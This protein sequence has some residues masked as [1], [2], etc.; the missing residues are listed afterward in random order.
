MA[1]PEHVYRQSVR[2]LSVVM[3]V[4]GLAII[5]STLARGGG[6]LSVGFLIG[7]AFLVVGAGRLYIARKSG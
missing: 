7:I 3:L 2:G 4:L 6:P 1:D 5:A